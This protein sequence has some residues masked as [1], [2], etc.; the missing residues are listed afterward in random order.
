MASNLV[1]CGGTG[2]HVAVALLRLHTLGH[3]VGFFGIDEFPDLFLL[4]QDHG[5]AAREGEETAWQVACK[6]L[7]MHPAQREW[8]T[9][10]RVGGPAAHEVSPL[11]VGAKNNWF[12]SPN[13]IV[14]ERFKG[15][16]L[17]D[18]I[19]APRQLD[20]DM[21]QGMMA[22]P[23][24]GSLLF[25]LKTYDLLQNNVN[26]D[27]AFATLLRQAGR[28]V[29]VGSA[30]GGT[31]ASVGPTVARMLA[32]GKPAHEVLAVML[33]EWFTFPVE[34]ADRELNEKA[35]IRNDVMRENE[36][37]AL[38]YYGKALADEL[39]VLPLGVP[40]AAR[41][42]RTYTRDL[43]Q[44][45]V[46]HYLHAVAALAT[47]QHLHKPL[48]AGLHVYGTVDRALLH[49]RTPTPW[50]SLQSM[51]DRA[52]ALVELLGVV[53]KVQRT[54]Y[55]R[56]PP[57]LFHAVS[58]LHARPAEVA[59]EVGKLAAHLNSQLTWMAAT[60]GIRARSMPSALALEE[61]L[62]ERLVRVPMGRVETDP[63]VAAERV[64]KWLS[65]WVSESSGAFP[66][67]DGAVDA[68]DNQLPDLRV[69]ENAMSLAP[70]KPGAVMPV[71]SERVDVALTGLVHPERLAA[72]G[73][74][75]PIAFASFFADALVR[76]RLRERRQLQLLLVGLVRGVFRLVE[77]PAPSG[78]A[79][80][81][82]DKLLFDYASTAGSAWEGLAGNLIEWPERTKTGEPFC[83]GCTSPATLLCPRPYQNNG[84]DRELWQD[85]AVRITGIER[86]RAW[87]GAEQFPA[88][89]SWPQDDSLVKMIKAWLRD[90][91]KDHGETT[92]PGWTRAFDGYPD[93]A[94]PAPYRPATQLR[95]RWDA[96]QSSGLRFVEVA[97][98]SDSEQDDWQ[99]KAD[100][101][102]LSAERAKD[103][104]P[105]LLGVTTPEQ[106]TFSQVDLRMPSAGG[107][108]RVTAIWEDHLQELVRLRKIRAFGSGTNAKVH[109]AVDVQGVMHV[110]TIDNTLL[111]RRRE[112][113]ID[114]VFPIAEHGLGGARSVR[115]P[116][117]PVRA[118]YL[119][120][121]LANDNDRVLRRLSEETY[122]IPERPTAAGDR[123][124]W[125]PDP[126]GVGEGQTLRWT[127][128]MAGR[129]DTLSVHVPNVDVEPIRAHWAVW[130]AFRVGALPVPQAQAQGEADGE[131]TTAAEQEHARGREWTTYYLFQR[132]GRRYLGTDAVWLRD[133]GVYV[134]RHLPS[135]QWN[136]QQ[137]LAEP[138]RWKEGAGAEPGRHDGGAPCA[139]VL[140]NM[141]VEDGGAEHGCYW[142]RLAPVTQRGPGF[143]L[144]VDFGTSHSASAVS[145]ATATEDAHLSFGGERAAGSATSATVVAD[146]D[147]VDLRPGGMI[148]DARWWPT[149]APSQAS[150]LPSEIVVNR[151]IDSSTA[152]SVSRWVPGRDFRLPSLEVSSEVL[153][154]QVVTDFKWDASQAE[155]AGQEPALRRQYLRSFLEMSLVRVVRQRRQTPAPDQTVDVTFTWPLRSTVTQAE[156]YR[157]LVAGVL[158][159]LTSTTGI[160]LR[161]AGA[162]GVGLYDESRAARVSTEEA[163]TIYV[164]AD[165]GG[166]TLDLLVSGGRLPG[167]VEGDGDV[168]DSIRVGGNLLLRHL[169]SNP[170]K[171][172]PSNGGWDLQNKGAAY[173]QLRAWMR[174]LGSPHLFGVDPRYGQ[175]S[176]PDLKLKGF[177]NRADAGAAREILNRYFGMIVDYLARTLVA[178][179]R[180]MAPEHAV[181][182]RLGVVLQLR[183]NGWR[184]DHSYTT[185]AELAV[186]VQAEVRARATALLGHI[187]ASS[188][189][190]HRLNE[191]QMWIDPS[192]YLS[193]D[194][195]TFPV[196]N[197]L[198]REPMHPAAVLTRARSYAMVEIDHHGTPSSF[199]WYGTLPLVT[200]NS[201]M[202]E[203][204]ALKPP[205]SVGRVNGSEVE[206]ATLPPD[207]RGAINRTL[208]RAPSDS[209]TG[210][211]WVPLSA[212]VYEACF[213]S[214]E[215]APNAR[216]DPL[217]GQ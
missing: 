181:P 42:R 40:A 146:R 189:L 83:V 122:A 76:G 119:D 206:I 108:T 68:H 186:R 126:E 159:E 45:A 160:T 201:R 48:K 138:V 33:L 103:L 162:G 116:D 183:G 104:R 23:A 16:P 173:A 140:R 179:L 71:Q 145:G 207:V 11:P 19:L 99:P 139:L 87:D 50:G 20:I 46:E 114:K 200:P 79:G 185:H 66:E 127:L 70:A 53:E 147:Y 155:F 57:G 97:L 77:Q 21:M 10:G 154:G 190:A 55:A 144:A 111:L 125:Q 132:T 177:T 75:D 101:P 134:S 203:V 4:D 64:V 187:D 120:L 52:G 36:S 196:K 113:F 170:E 211:L 49:A 198:R 94:S 180:D 191:A 105:L 7:S 6:L 129:T 26:Q 178:Y 43:Q 150:M 174:M 35:Q 197:V 152:A 151:R 62:R 39:A 14:R 172:L 12:A 65:A 78:A 60:L 130:P 89:M 96:P 193:E 2:A 3:L 107:Q 92:A 25:K 93:S 214:V 157:S 56:L 34:G 8:A 72:N 98:P 205:I 32:R 158:A 176:L 217:H 121:V 118:A 28:T 137:A 141:T 91:R 149:S 124:S 5:P 106:T 210:E 167:R 110:H 80:P 85:I 175:A 143:S 123:G 171:Y 86:E 182:G 41:A 58:S 148:V 192:P 136:G 81:T 128:R 112:V 165:L 100:T 24:T 38:Q 164:V 117:V 142:V 212:L 194:P 30:V 131:P 13:N 156:E 168:A 161:L 204:R 15:E 213:T 115:Y 102:K 73:W 208:Q 17:R 95:V 67:S 88:T 82:L 199:P 215:V 135:A 166:G 74:P 209:K 31:G 153:A 47:L 195:K 69:A 44:A 51:A 1:L 22:S 54:S 63:K 90:V 202:V 61:R 37:S 84:S 133:G 29:V 163:G 9:S 169:A 216:I 109:V 59:D 27:A 18:V 184:L 188:S